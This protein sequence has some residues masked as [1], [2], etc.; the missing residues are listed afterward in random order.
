MWRISLHIRS[1]E[2]GY[3]ILILDTVEVKWIMWR[4]KQSSTTTRRFIATRSLGDI[5]P[6]SNGG[7][8]GAIIIIKH[9]NKRRCST[10]T[11]RRTR[12]EK[13]CPSSPAPPAC[14]HRACSHS[15]TSAAEARLHPQP[16][17]HKVSPDTWSTELLFLTFNSRWNVHVCR[18]ALAL[19]TDSHIHKISCAV[20]TIWHILRSTELLQLEEPVKHQRAA[21]SNTRNPTREASN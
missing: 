16:Q 15:Q 21:A 3:I 8:S 4:F 12:G 17:T 18:L 5:S 19:I 2:A 10:V 13:N 1:V 14:E 20:E 11:F 6:E 9:P 7:C